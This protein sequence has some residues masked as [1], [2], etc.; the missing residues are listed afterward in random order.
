M[1]P[2]YN[3]SAFRQ[4][5][6]FEVKHFSFYLVLKPFFTFYK[7]FGA[8]FD[9]LGSFLSG[10]WLLFFFWITFGRVLSLSVPFFSFLLL[11]DHFSAF[12]RFC[13][14]FLSFWFL[15]SLLFNFFSH[16]LFH[17]RPLALIMDHFL[18]FSYFSVCDSPF[19]FLAFAESS[20]TISP[21]L[22]MVNS[23]SIYPTV[24]DFKR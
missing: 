10:F 9:F 21:Q 14:N 1:L 5:H 8:L 4:F 17:I 3:P 2:L 16:F 15:L 13:S 11:L 12:R 23:S 24:V 18:T 19:H 20:F 22:I 6:C 7:L